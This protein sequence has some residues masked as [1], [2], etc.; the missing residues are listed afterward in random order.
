MSLFDAFM[1]AIDNPE[2]AASVNQLGSIVGT[3][4]Q[5]SG[6][7]GID[8][9]M[10]QTVM[11][12]VGGQVRSSLQEQR[13][14]QG[15]PHV[16]NLIG[17]LSGATASSSALSSLFSP[18]I[19]QQLAQAVAQKT[20]LDANMIVGLLPMLVPLAMNFLQGGS[21]GGTQAAGA[22]Q[23]SAGNPL[24][25]M[26]LDQDQDGDVDLGD[27]MNMASKFMQNR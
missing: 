24:L 27:A 4:Q 26:F 13:S 1:G 20:G 12:M 3:V 7:N 21:M 22:P 15:E 19:Q 16:Q 18:Q 23:A 10:M 17:Q 14:T 2:Q 6:Q 8:P 9:A 25:N 11:S 5:L